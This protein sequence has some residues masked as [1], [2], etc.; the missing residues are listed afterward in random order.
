[1]AMFA[2]DIVGDSV[3]IFNLRERAR[4]YQ[5]LRQLIL[6][7]I[8]TNDPEKVYFAQVFKD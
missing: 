8:S 1:M 4:A 3:D 6:D 7:V 5:T 2:L